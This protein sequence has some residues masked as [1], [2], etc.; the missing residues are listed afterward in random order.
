LTNIKINRFTLMITLF[1]LAACNGRLNSS[2]PASFAPSLSSIQVIVASKDFLVGQPRVPLILR[3]GPQWITDV[4]QVEVTAFNLAEEPPVLTWQGT[5]TGYNDYAV[6]YWVVYPEISQAGFWGLAIATTMSDGTIIES[7]IAIQVVDEIESPATGHQ[8]P[9]SHNRTLE[10]ETDIHKLTSSATPNPGL[11]QMTVAEAMDSGKPTV[12]TFA[13][14]AFCQTRYCAPVVESVAEVYETW[15]DRVNF[16]H[17]EIYKEFNPLVMAD[18]VEEWKL[19]SEP[20]TYVL[21]NEGVVV[22][23]FGGP[24]SPRELTI[25]LTDLF[26]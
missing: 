11:Y 5:A 7:Q 13:T 25:A 3:D 10:T 22:A 26:P 12:I 20:W 21:D 2:T 15:A 18:E 17:L 16:I 23:R 1:L 19:T 4:S 6:P 14:P 9:A 24:V 8:P